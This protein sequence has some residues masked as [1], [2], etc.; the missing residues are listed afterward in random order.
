[1]VRESELDRQTEREIGRG[2][3]LSTQDMGNR[4]GE[5]DFPNRV[6]E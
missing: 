5:E 6:V 4:K 3:I 2:E 1:M